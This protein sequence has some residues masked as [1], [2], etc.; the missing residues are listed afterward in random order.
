MVR[1]IPGSSTGCR[2]CR[3]RKIKVFSKGQHSKFHFTQPN[4]CRQCDEGMPACDKCLKSGRHCKGYRAPKVFINTFGQLAKL[5]PVE[6]GFQGQLRAWKNKTILPLDFKRDGS[7]S[8][9]S[10]TSEDSPPPESA[11]EIMSLR[12]MDNRGATRCQFVV[13]VVENY[14]PMRDDIICGNWSTT[15]PDLLGKNEGLDASLYGLC[16]T[17]VGR[18]QGNHAMTQQSYL[19]Y[20][21]GVSAL[22]QRAQRANMK[23]SRGENV[24]I[25]EEHLTIAAALM[26]FE[27]RMPPCSRRSW[28]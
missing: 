5:A 7:T 26:N 4:F 8:S 28:Y 16:M 21:E 3:A 19:H 18:R 13:W 12:V 10:E 14:F 11:P 20:A 27:V 17:L 24:K 1:R 25:T 22:S 2:T 6:L 9:N 23:I 15:W